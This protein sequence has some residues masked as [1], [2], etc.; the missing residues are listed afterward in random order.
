LFWANRDSYGLPVGSN[1]SRILAEAS[2]IEVDEYLYSHKVKFCR[3]V[4][5]YRIF[6]KDSATAQ[7]HLSLLVAKLNSVGLFLNSRK[8]KVVDVSNYS[9]NSNISED[10][11]IDSPSSEID[12]PTNDITSNLEEKRNAFEVSKIIRGYSENIP[13][14]FRKLT[15]NESIKSQNED[16]NKLLSE[17][18]TTVLLDPIDIVKLTKTIVAT[19]SFS[20][21][22]EYHSLLLKFP[23]FLPYITDV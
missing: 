20:L 11:I 12:P 9:I 22:T 2:L 13:T 4:D 16:P 21:L 15:V 7:H 18:K 6:A 8:T 5:D 17:M 10:D 19:E 23:Q 3:F 14:K 1:V